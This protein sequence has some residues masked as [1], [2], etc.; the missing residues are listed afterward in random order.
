M[1]IRTPNETCVLRMVWGQCAGGLCR[2]RPARRRFT[3]IS[4]ALVTCLCT[5]NKLLT[6]GMTSTGAK[7]VR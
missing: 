1:K 5:A 3:L 4:H 6:T 2:H 7:K